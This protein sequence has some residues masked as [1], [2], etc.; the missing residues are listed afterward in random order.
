V[1]ERCDFEGFNW[2]VIKLFSLVT[3][4]V[5]EGEGRFNKKKTSQLKWKKPTKGRTRFFQ[6]LEIHYV[7][8]TNRYS[9]RLEK[10]V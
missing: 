10:E 4:L 1:R 3:Q 5:K 7:I 6:N 2:T 9:K 8:W